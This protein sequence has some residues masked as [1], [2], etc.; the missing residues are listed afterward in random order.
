VAPYIQ[1]LN[2]GARP[3]FPHLED[4]LMKWFTKARSQLKTVT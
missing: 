3:K 2:I 1:K 4:E